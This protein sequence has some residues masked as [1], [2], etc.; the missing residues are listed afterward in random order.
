MFR[1]MAYLINQSSVALAAASVSFFLLT[2][3]T[4]MVQM[5]VLPLVVTGAKVN[6]RCVQSML[7]RIK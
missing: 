5:M 2:V 3:L 7:M 1:A 4:I 6:S